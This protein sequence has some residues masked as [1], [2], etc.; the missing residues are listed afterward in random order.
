MGRGVRLAKA[1]AAFGVA[2][3]A[4]GVLVAP[5]RGYEGVGARWEKLSEYR[6]AH[7]GLHD[8][9]TPAPENSL[10]AFRLAREWGYGSELDVH[11]TADGQLV[12]IHDSRLQRACGV[13]GV[14]EEKTLPELADLRLF[15][16][17]E[18]IPTFAQ[19][20]DVYE[21]GEGPCP[22]LVVELKTYGANYAQLAECAMAELD[23]HQ[24]PYCVE[25]FDPRVLWWLRR[26]R[27]EVVR[28]QL[29]ENFVLDNESD[30]GFVRGVTHG[31]LMCNLFA[32]PDFVAYRH[33][34]RRRLAVWLACNLLGAR[35]VTWTIKSPQ[36]LAEVE[37]AGGV[38]IFEGF[39]PGPLKDL[40]EGGHA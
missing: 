40:S 4:F 27:P 36:E 25:S 5:R 9:Q 18:G 31:A 26:N 12:V 3:F 39:E 8:N 10:A 28:G 17:R 21:G 24:V 30:I 32:R 38:G 11:L 15:G 16:T 20:L 19:V 14:V 1:A 7:R 13:E 34:H 22:P 23:A 2:G 6:Y 35:L 29:S 33:D 37:A